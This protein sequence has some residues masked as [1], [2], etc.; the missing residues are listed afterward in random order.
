MSRAL[1]PLVTPCNTS[2]RTRSNASR[3]ARPT[4]AL[5]LSSPRSGGNRDHL[6]TRR[7]RT[8]IFGPT[9]RP[10]APCPPVAKNPDNFDHV[11]WGYYAPA[12]QVDP[13]PQARPAQTRGCC[14]RS[15]DCTSSNSPTRQGRL[16]PPSAPRL[17][18]SRTRRPR[19][20]SAAVTPSGHGGKPR[21]LIT[22]PAA[23]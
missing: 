7:F 15:T 20:P 8:S 11:Q 6:N 13:T 19:P 22:I 14:D 16:R 1:L 21:V 9:C 5:S 18:T 4:L 2:M 10:K 3:P 23:S 17:E 12:E